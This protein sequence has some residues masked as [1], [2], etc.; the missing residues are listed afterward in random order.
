[1]VKSTKTQ[2]EEIK[3]LKPKQDKQKLKAKPH[4]LQTLSKF[5]AISSHT[6]EE[7]DDD[8]SSILSE[9]QKPLSV[10]FIF[11]LLLFTSSLQALHSQLV[12]DTER[13][14]PESLCH[15]LHL[16]DPQLWHCGLRAQT[17]CQVERYLQEDIVDG[18]P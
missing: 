9:Q 15:L 7:E 4:Y 13:V 18:K 8:A 6:Q 11:S 12:S 5:T 3:V 10:S 17:H 1:M 2:L 16:K 14:L